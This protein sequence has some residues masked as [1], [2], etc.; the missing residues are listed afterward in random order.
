M[1]ILTTPSPENRLRVLNILGVEVSNLSQHEAIAMLETAIATK[2]FTKVAFLN[3][4]CANT[5]V[6]D[7]SFAD[8]LA[9]FLVLPDGIGV[10]IAAS[11]LYGHP[12]S[13][14]LNGTDF[15][16]ALLM[17]MNRPLT[18]GVVGASHE[19]GNLATV[20]LVKKIPQHR[21]VYLNDGFLSA[22]QEPEVIARIRDL[23]PDILLVAMGVPRQ[24]KWIAKNL[25]SASCTVPIA[26]GALLDF[27]SG[28]VPRAPKIM[29]QLRMEWVFRLCVEPARLWRRY[30]IGNPV[31]LIRI[32][33]QK[34]RGNT[35]K[36][37]L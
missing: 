35:G 24:E 19:N 31:F 12:F 2:S 7:N 37:A 29:R 21:F 4:H 36:R 13:E 33:A 1:N 25:D 14:N 26:V 5:A 17:S 15:V 30:I 32:A 6:N 3:A 22:E 11:V 16:P 9:N 8:I 34:L 23:R 10:D 20:D 18:I 28:S 27:L